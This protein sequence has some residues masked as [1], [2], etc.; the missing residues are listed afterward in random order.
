MCVC[1]FSSLNVCFSTQSCKIADIVEPAK[2][3][4]EYAYIM[5]VL[6]VTIVFEGLLNF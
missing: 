4:T 3:S 2:M 5:T 1:V 6:L